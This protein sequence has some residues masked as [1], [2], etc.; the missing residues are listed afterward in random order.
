MH[1]PDGFLSPP[2]W[3]TLDV[4]SAGAVVA[5]ARRVEATGEERQVPLMGVTAAFIHG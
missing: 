4:A 3:A 1:L 2:V 5:A